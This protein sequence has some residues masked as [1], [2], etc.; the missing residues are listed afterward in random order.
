VGGGGASRALDRG[1]EAAE[2]AVDGEPRLRRGSGEVESSGKRKAV[3]M[4]VCE[5]KSKSVG[6]SRMCSRSRRRHHCM[7]VAAG[8]RRE[9]WWLG[10][11]AARRGEAGRGPARAG[12]QRRG[13]WGG[14]WRRGKRRGGS[15]CSAHGRQGRRGSGREENRAGGLE[16]DEGGLSCKFPKVQGLHCKA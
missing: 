9:A 6:S 5:R 4:H 12:K 15:R 8:N 14:T 11:T 2:V 16:V 10:A 13:C 1:W 3:K 7:G